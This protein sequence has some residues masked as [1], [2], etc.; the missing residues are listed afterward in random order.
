MFRLLFACFVTCSVYFYYAYG[1]CLI[2]SQ[3][4]YIY[5][6]VSNP[7]HCSHA[8]SNQPIAPGNSVLNYTICKQIF[9][10]REN[11]SIY[12]VLKTKVCSIGN[13]ITNIPDGCMVV[14]DGCTSTLVQ[15]ADNTQPCESQN[16][17]G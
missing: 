5:G 10:S 4:L 8:D 17:N 9:C 2:D 11:S 16:A 14:K 15:I 7:T 6:S 1:D 13:S 12:Y 3:M